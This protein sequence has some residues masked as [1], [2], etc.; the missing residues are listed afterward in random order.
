MANG[1]SR[2]GINYTSVRE[3]IYAE[4]FGI[5]TDW[6]PEQE[7][8]RLPADGKIAFTSRVEL[9]E[10]TARLMVRGG[11]DR[12]IVLLTSG[13]A[14]SPP[15]VVDVINET[16]GRQVKVEFLPRDEYIRHSLEN[17]PRNKPKEHYE[18]V[19]S[20][21]EEFAHGSASTTDPLMADLLE[22]EPTKSTE[23]IKQLL[24]GDRDY[25]YS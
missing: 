18:M 8:I 1:N 10:A 21:W 13:E 16:T 4:A 9:A 5:M 25:T 7:L 19:A 3:G 24:Q 6:Y 20:W 14:L 23:A 17:N 12:Q 2:S 15:Q 11:H 22:R